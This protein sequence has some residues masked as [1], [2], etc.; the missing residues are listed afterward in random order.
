MVQAA[1]WL[2]AGFVVEWV[3]QDVGKVAFARK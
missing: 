1:A 3:D 2:T